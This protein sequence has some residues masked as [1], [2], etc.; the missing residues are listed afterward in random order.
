MKINHYLGNKSLKM[1][2][3]NL[4]EI[5]DNVR[6]RQMDFSICFLL[7]Q[8]NLWIMCYCHQI[9]E[10]GKADNIEYQYITFKSIS[11]T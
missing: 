10:R 9:I 4:Q 8:E 7:Y 5:K 11:V 2:K 1:Q 3:K 6:H